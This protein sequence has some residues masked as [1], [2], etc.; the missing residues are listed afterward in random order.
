M[1]P[2][3]WALHSLLLVK[4]VIHVIGEELRDETKVFGWALIV[5]AEAGKVG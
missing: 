3:S 1:I 4:H 2:L 5:Q